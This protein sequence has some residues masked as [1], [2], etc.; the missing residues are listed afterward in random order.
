MVRGLSSRVNEVSPPDYDTPD[1]PKFWPRFWPDCFLAH[2]S[3]KWGA[4]GLAST[5]PPSD[6]DKLRERGETWAVDPETRDAIDRLRAD[7]LG[8]F[9]SSEDRTHI[10]VDGAIGASAAETRAYIDGQLRTSAA[11]TRTY[12]D[13]RIQISAAETRT[14][15]DER[16]QTSAVETRRH[17]DVVAESL[18]ADMRGLAEAMALSNELSHQRFGEQSGRSDGLGDRV[19]RLEAR[20]TTLEEVDRKPRRR[21]RRR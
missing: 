12:V 5:Y 13:E 16:I 8:E 17:F 11:E 15:V 10:F 7:L 14:Y 4:L 9:R 1:F 18:R 6:V 2:P 19:L 20:V 21:R 3:F